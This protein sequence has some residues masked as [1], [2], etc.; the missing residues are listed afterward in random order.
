VPVKITRI[1]ELGDAWE[2]DRSGLPKP[3]G[4]I[5]GS[6]PPRE[7]VKQ[8]LETRLRNNARALAAQRRRATG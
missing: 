1:I 8:G 3:R 7:L 2:D 4:G 5:R 6:T